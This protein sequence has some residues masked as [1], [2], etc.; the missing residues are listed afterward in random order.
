M[1]I[2]Y[3]LWYNIPD[4]KFKAEVKQQMRH[5]DWHPSHF[6]PDPSEK[7]ADKIPQ[8]LAPFWLPIDDEQATPISWH[9]LLPSSNVV[10]PDMLTVGIKLQAQVQTNDDRR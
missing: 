3:N 1:T 6:D 9:M 4:H 7:V 8:A 5:T 10:I 2:H